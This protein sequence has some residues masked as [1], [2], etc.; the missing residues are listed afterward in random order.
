MILL[1]LV[2][3]MKTIDVARLKEIIT[4]PLDF[5][6]IKID[7]EPEGTLFDKFK[8][9]LF[10]FTAIVFALVFVKVFDFQNIDSNNFYTFFI[11]F[12]AIISYLLLKKGIERLLLYLFSLQ[13]KINDF[14]RTKSRSF[15]AI[16]FVLYILLILS[17]FSQ[18]SNNQLSW[19][20]IGLFLFRFVFLV[21][22]NKN[23]IFNKLFYFILY[24]C[25]LEI[26]PLIIVYKLMLETN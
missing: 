6:A 13:R 3:F 7:D 9:I 22:K 10:F 19:L 14:L 18:L 8:V 26:A 21:Y 17:Q 4:T 15:H 24:I 16:S 1:I 23:L 12:I 20:I 25:T 5:S 2:F 11:I